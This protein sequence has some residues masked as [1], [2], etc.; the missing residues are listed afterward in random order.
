MRFITNLKLPNLNTFFPIIYP[1]SGFQIKPFLKQMYMGQEI[2]VKW[3]L[4]GKAIRDAGVYTV[5]LFMMKQ[6]C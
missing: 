6:P 3:T 1:N 5:V 2:N 4:E